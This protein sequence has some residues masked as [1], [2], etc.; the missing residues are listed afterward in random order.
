MDGF[1]FS[2][3]VVW[4]IVLAGVIGVLESWR[5][6]RA[7]AERTCEWIRDLE[8]Q[9]REAEGLDQEELAA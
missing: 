6:K 9:Q 8:Q 7:Q 5:R 3:I 1:H 2:Q 4:V